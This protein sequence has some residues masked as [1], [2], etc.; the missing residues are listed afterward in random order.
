MALWGSLF[1]AV[2]LGYQFMHI[3]SG[4][5]P[6]ILMF[7]ALR[8]TVCGGLVSLYCLLRQKKLGQGFLAWNFKVVLHEL[9]VIAFLKGVET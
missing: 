1:P 6:D 5:V 8:F 3:P 4:S 9:A 2:K 7:A